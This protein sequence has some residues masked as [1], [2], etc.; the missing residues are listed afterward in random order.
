MFTP[1]MRPR[2]RSGVFIWRIV[3]R[4]TEETVS[5]AP[6]SANSSHESARL[7]DRPKSVVATP[8]SATLTSNTSP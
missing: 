2:M 4:M 7:V 8:Y 6:V 1:L 3:L 5:P